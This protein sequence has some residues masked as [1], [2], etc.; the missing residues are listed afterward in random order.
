MRGLW[1]AFAVACSMPPE[2]PAAPPPGLDGPTPHEA[3]GHPEPDPPPPALDP[4]TVC[5]RAQACC[6]AFAEVTPNVA[7]DV[8][9]AEPA[10]AAGAADADA[11]CERMIIGWR[12]A[13]ELHDGLEMPDACAVPERRRRRR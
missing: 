5:G 7:A 8:A 12:A 13:L 10:D 1:I 9:C 2:A 4:S 6:R 11:R 3:D